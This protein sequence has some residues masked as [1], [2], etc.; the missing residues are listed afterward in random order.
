MT[1]VAYD[2]KTMAADT[3]ATDPWG[4]KETFRDKIWQ[5]HY[6]LIGCAGDAGQIASWLRTLRTDQRMSALL[7]DGYPPFVIDKNDPALLVVDRLSGAIYRHASGCFLALDRTFFAIGSG[8]DYALAAMHL[9]KTAREAVEVAM[10]FDNST[11]GE[12]VAVKASPGEAAYEASAP[13]TGFFSLPD[14]A[15]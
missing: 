11:G 13:A 15:E 14:D 6:L 4:L 9:G 1:T 8:R 10:H 2:G 7:A 5:N 3:L 12:V